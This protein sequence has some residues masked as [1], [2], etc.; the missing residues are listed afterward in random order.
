MYTL[1]Q[2]HL[3]HG[4]LCPTGALLAAVRRGLRL[5][6]LVHR[7]L[8][9]SRAGRQRVRQPDALAL[10]RAQLGLLSDRQG[11]LRC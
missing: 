2:Q 9:L 8:D 7:A 3:L 1:F 5:P 6:E 4:V 10:G 11:C